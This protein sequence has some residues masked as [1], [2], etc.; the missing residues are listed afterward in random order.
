MHASADERREK[1]LSLGATRLKR[2]N[3]PFAYGLIMEAER[4]NLLEAALSDLGA[5]AGEL[6]RY[7]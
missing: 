2:Y 7:L 3:F 4:L 6:R 5:R 1:N